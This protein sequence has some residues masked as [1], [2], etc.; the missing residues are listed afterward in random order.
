ML[1]AVV[2][3]DCW[4]SPRQNLPVAR[5]TLSSANPQGIHVPPGHATGSVQL[6]PEAILMIFSSGR[7]EAASSDDFRFPVNYWPILQENKS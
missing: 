4:P 5:F 1:V 7:I 6:N 2:R 3:P